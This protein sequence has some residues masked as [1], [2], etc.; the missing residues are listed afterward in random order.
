MALHMYSQLLFSKAHVYD[1]PWSLV[2]AQTNIQVYHICLLPIG[3]LL[4]NPKLSQVFA[5]Y[6]PGKKELH[7]GRHEN[8]RTEER[9]SR[10]LKE[11]S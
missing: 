3:R 2:S 9:G 5:L 7:N 6:F 8:C 11:I 10:V 4:I 1:A